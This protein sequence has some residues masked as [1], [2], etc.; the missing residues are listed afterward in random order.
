[1]KTIILIFFV[2]VTAV[3]AVS[4]YDLVEEEWKYFKA[5]Y[6]KEYEPDEEK[7]RMKVFME[8]KYKILKHNALYEKG[9]HSFKLR[10]NEYGDMLQHEFVKTMNGFIGNR[11]NESSMMGST[12][13][14]PANVELPDEVDWRKDGAVTGVKNQ[15]NC[16]SCWAFSST[17]SLEGQHFRKTGVLV[18][19]SEQNLMDCSSTYGNQGCNGGT[20]DAAFEYV[21]DNNGIDTENSY[22]Y[23]AR[24]GECRYDPNNCGATDTGFVDID[25][26]SE[27]NLQEAVATKGPISVGIDASQSSFHF[28]DTGVYYEPNCSPDN[29]DHGV[30]VV[31]YGTDADSG[32]E[33]WLV[34]NSW[35]TSWG[36]KGY[37][38][39]ARNRNNNCGIATM[40]SF[41]LV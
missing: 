29:L 19:L 34:K 21:R 16:G 37:I 15:G 5:T 17:G 35:G 9:Q 23:E 36:E 4:L 26:G 12:F 14:S 20:M 31:G 41:P 33:Y 24:D 18:S 25:Q 1:M 40:A 13:I 28:Y 7:I 30:L 32:E 6:G 3:Q 2:T 39:M 22:P 8:N 10:M 27:S 38:R 11:M